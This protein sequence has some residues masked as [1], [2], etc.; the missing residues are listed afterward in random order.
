[1]NPDTFFLMPVHFSKR[2]ATPPTLVC[3]RLTR[4]PVATAVARK[5]DSAYRF[6]AL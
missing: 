3:S 6:A 5:R 1:M 2:H 4:A